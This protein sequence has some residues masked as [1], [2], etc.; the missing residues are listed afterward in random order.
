[1]D[2]IYTSE[3]H[4]KEIG[5]PGHLTSLRHSANVAL[6]TPVENEP[7]QLAVLQGLRKTPM[8]K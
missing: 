1:V 6:K 8:A 2:E 3:Q 5:L 7:L 4:L